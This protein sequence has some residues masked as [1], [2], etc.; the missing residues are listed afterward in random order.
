MF[1][2]FLLIPA[3]AQEKQPASNS[4]EDEYTDLD[5]A[6]QTGPDYVSINDKN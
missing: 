1:F 6:Q 3:A 2:E 4:G 5:P